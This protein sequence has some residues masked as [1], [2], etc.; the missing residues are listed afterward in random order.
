[1]AIKIRRGTNAYFDKTK[2][3]Q[4]EL[5]VITDTGE[6]Y[7]CFSAGNTKKL[8]TEEDLL[9]VL[10][11]SATAYSAL[12]QLIADLELNPSELTNIL[13]NITA[14]QSGK[15]DKTS[16]V[17]TDTVNDATKVPSSAVTFALGAQIDE[18][19]DNL[20]LIH[21]HID[22]GASLVF[23]AYTPSRS[24]GI[25][26][27]QHVHPSGYA[28]IYLLTYGTIPSFMITVMDASTSTGK[29]IFTKVQN[30]SYKWNITVESGYPA[31]LYFKK[32]I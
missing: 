16:I 3:V 8:Q 19:S 1:M 28:A 20:V 22:P 9:A 12:I 11:S 6:L 13:N 17:Q 27:I 24:Y 18:L 10:G 31:D 14:L 30:G 7:F 2:L 25:Y 32:V 21:Y 26:M 23:D 29:L 5:A 15:I 4:G